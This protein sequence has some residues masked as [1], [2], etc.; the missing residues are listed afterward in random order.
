MGALWRIYS[1]CAAVLLTAIILVVLAGV[2][3]ASVG[4]WAPPLLAGPADA[5][6]N[7]PPGGATP[8]A[9]LVVE[10]KE[11]DVNA[12]LARSEGRPPGVSDVEVHFQ[13]Q[14]LTLAA[15]MADPLPIKVE[16]WGTVE[17]QDGR[18]LLSLSGAKA[19]V[20][21]LP[22]A[23]VDVLERYANDSLARVD[24]TSDVYVEDVQLAPGV[25]RLTVRV[26]LAVS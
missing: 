15:T 7:G 11:A 3:L 17:V 5:P 12:V 4:A 8:S 16:A 20:L 1:G 10:M 6:A 13:N 19:G 24:G 2:T 21:P 18:P 25:V 9:R 14:G 26:P 22:R 23:M